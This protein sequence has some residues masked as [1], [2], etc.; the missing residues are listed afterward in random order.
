MPNQTNSKRIALSVPPELHKIIEELSELQSIP[1][2]KVILS[3]LEE[4]QPQLEALRDA[5]KAVKEGRNPNK[6]LAGMFADS[7]AELGAFLKGE[8]AND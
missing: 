6:I 8:D 2:T 5:L 4:I 7:F 3:L 1:K